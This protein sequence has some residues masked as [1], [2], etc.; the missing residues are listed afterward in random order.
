MSKIDVLNT[1]DCVLNYEALS[2][3]VKL[4]EEK[5]SHPMRRVDLTGAFSTLEDVDYEMMAEIKMCLVMVLDTLK[6]TK[7]Q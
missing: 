7:V 4:I 5:G 1:N 3:L 6:N 2:V